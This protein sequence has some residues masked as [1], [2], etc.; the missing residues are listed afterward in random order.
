MVCLLD[1]LLMMQSTSNQMMMSTHMN[2]YE[3][4]CMILYALDI[5]I[6]AYMSA[7]CVCVCVCVWVIMIMATFRYT[8]R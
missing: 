3:V 8:C 5:I 2:M 6:S 7:F 4:R 1:K